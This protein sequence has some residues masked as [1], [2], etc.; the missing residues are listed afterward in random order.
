MK[1]SARVILLLVIVELGL[2]GLWWYLLDALR[3]GQLRPSGS[4]AEAVSTTS[5]MLGGAMGVVA[6]L[7][8][9]TALV[10]RRRGR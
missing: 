8:L 3:T 6:G 5:S 1:P 4:M 7:F 9:V 10:L 2:A